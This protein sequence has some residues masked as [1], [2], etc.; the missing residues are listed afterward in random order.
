MENH[1]VTPH[2]K[3]KS[4]AVIGAG[5][6]GLAAAYELCKA[7]HKVDVYE[8]SPYIGGL[9]RS[10]A[11]WGQTVDMG[12]HRFFSSDRIVNALW[13]EV[14]GSDFNM[15]NRLTRIHYRNRFFFYPLQPL[16]AFFNLGP[17]KTFQ[18]IVSYL[19][20]KMKPSEPAKT[21]EDWVVSRF[22]R[23]L[24]EIFF[25]T[26]TE[27]VWGISCRQIDADW[28]SQRIKKLSLYE[29]IKAAFFKDKKQKHKTLIDQFAYPIGGTGNFYKKLVKKI[30]QLGGTVHLEHPV[31]S[32]MT[33]KTDQGQ[34]AIGIQLN[35]GEKVLSDI[36]IST[37]PLTV[38]VKHLAE[39][40]KA[41]VSAADE[42]YY[43]NTILAYVE[44]SGTHLFPDNWIYVHSPEVRHGR[45]TNFRNWCP[46]LFGSSQ[47]SI[48]CM[49][50][51]C[52][53]Q[54]PIWSETVENLGHQAVKELRQISIL[55]HGEEV[56]RTHI[57]KIPKSYPVYQTGFM[58]PL[59]T[60][61]NHVDS[62]EGLYAIG[63]NGAF[64]YNN[65]D[66]SILMGLL[67]S[68]EITS[69]ISQNLWNIN[70]DDEYQEQAI[71]DE[72]NLSK[73]RT[74]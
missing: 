60:I 35:S 55:P 64:K 31:A 45:I 29:A 28:A 57:V 13:H 4:I 70:T 6:A 24:F 22:G 61:Q 14:I 23:R 73:A 25:K 26:Y 56:L 67:V 54:D 51:W 63:R 71:T 30:T 53:D 11:L 20:T 48:L 21:F 8:A 52:F 36:V 5:P 41:V 62:I 34:K 3:A 16:N 50:F 12:P 43:R 18:C 19:F 66:H 46:S 33:V 2:F 65:Q 9:S 38:M 32:V 39:A 47:S 69:G 17:I 72:V 37:M 59:E 15:V 68:K 44:V 40:P 27:K 42:L 58:K 74:V 1:Y 7:G 49:E 10:F